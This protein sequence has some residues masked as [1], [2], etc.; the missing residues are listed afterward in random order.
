M[1]RFLGT[2]LT[3]TLLLGL[4]ILFLTAGR[5]AAAT[6][7]DDAG[8]QLEFAA[9][10]IRVVSLVP[11]AT[12]VMEAIGAA[13]SLAGLTYH[14]THLAGLAGKPVV[15]GAFTPQWDLIAE[16]KPDL[17]IVAPRLAAEAKAKMARTP[18]MVWNDGASLKEADL[19]IGWLGEMFHKSAA[20]EKVRMDN[21][22]L[23]ALIARKTA[24]IP[25]EK[26]LRVMRL[27]Q[28]ETGPL[29]PGEDSFQSEM[30]AAAGGIAP[31][32]GP[33]AFVPVHLDAWKR[34]D[35]QVIY[36]CG[37]DQTELMNFL[38]QPGW[39]EAEAVRTK[40]VYFFPCALTCRA[41][42]H[43]G[44]FT[45]WFS[46]MI[47]GNHFA[48]RTSLALP[49]KILAERPVEMS[50]PYVKKARIVESRIFD[51]IHRTLLVDFKTPRLIIATSGGQKQVSTVGNS[52]SPPPTWGIYHALGYARSQQDLFKVLRLDPKKAEI[53]GT[54]ADLNNLVVKSAGFKD[55]TV[56][57][58]ITAGV[59]DN[60][61]RA[62]KDSGAYYEPGTINIIVLVSHALSPRAAARAIITVTEAKTAALWDMDVR[63][64]QSALKNPATGT[65]TDDVIVV[66]GNLRPEL[67]SSGGHSK[68]GQLIAET[69]YAGVQEALV[70]Q[71]GKLP[72]RNVFERLDERGLS[73]YGLLGGPDCPCQSG[74]SDFQTDFERLLLT[75]RYRAFIEAAFSLSD[76][77]EMGQFSDPAPF[78]AW[79]LEVAGEIAGRPVERIENIINNRPGL[80]EIPATALN[81]LG[82]GLKHRPGKVEK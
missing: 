33:G 34:F 42:A 45:A 66:S 35:P 69:V 71:N 72:V 36:A 22:E 8:Q 60:A 50:I 10:P 63:S 1:K 61:L 65:G 53:L 41:A 67:I 39:N 9:P 74:G 12:E 29:T 46:S 56:T 81:A 6:V 7:I 54:G 49:E 28:T 68:L 17:L 37:P 21:R 58:L 57:A 47:Y 48:D 77:A 32:M 59:T 79:A 51:F 75:P 44:Y 25:K 5:L 82:T 11:A 18:I 73:V 19:K 52:F 24:Q 23:L 3:N 13:D 70:Q 43:T 30:I 31:K 62:G 40:R 27:L 38:A 26:H 20:A 14:D 78:G 64:V 80:P 55:L 16:A 4:F 15:G 76:A 2:W